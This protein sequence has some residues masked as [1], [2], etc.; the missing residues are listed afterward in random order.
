MSKVDKLRIPDYLSHILE[1]IERIREYTSELGEAGFL[2]DQ[3]TQDAVIRNIEII[4]EASRNILQYHPDFAEKNKMIP[5]NDIY[6]MRNRV[7][8]GYFAIDLEI[9]WRTIENDL[10]FLEQQIKKIQN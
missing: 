2:I 8:H 10:P 9:V 5:W 4:G 1:A 6:T 3:K 7:S